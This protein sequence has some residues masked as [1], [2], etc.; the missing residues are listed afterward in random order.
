VSL[1]A[2]VAIV[3]VLLMLIGRFCIYRVSR[4]AALIEG[5]G[6]LGD[7]IKSEPRL[8]AWYRFGQSHYFMGIAAFA[9]AFF[10]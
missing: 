9:A 6:P 2:I 4:R 3:G 1:K 7:R 5:Q 8:Q 10:L